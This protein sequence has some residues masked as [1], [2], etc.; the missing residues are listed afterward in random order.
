MNSGQILERAETNGG[1]NK[2]NMMGANDGEEE[3][4]LEA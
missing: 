1:A 4:K 3:H 2:A